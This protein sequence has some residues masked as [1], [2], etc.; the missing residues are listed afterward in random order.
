[1]PAQIRMRVQEKAQV[2]FAAKWTFEMQLSGLCLCLFHSS[3]FSAAG[4]RKAPWRMACFEVCV[5]CPSPFGSSHTQEGL[6]CFRS[7]KVWKT[8]FAR[9]RWSVAVWSSFV[10]CITLRSAS[11]Q[12]A[13]TD[14]RN[15]NL[16]PQTIR[17]IPVTGQ[18]LSTHLYVFCLGGCFSVG[19][20]FWKDAKIK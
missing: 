20:Q 17:Q 11:S 5:T 16:H 3:D 10:F 4:N 6:C 18:T 15:G 1:M 19:S 9:V 2:V 8:P 7:C 12:S 14:R 13:D